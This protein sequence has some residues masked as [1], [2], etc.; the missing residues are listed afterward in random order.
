MY[1]SFMLKI[2]H[3][4]KVRLTKQRKSLVEAAK[5]YAKDLGIDNVDCHVNIVFTHMLT[6][7][8]F[9]HA[10]VNNINERRINILI[11]AKMKGNDMGLSTMAHEMVHVKQY[12]RKELGLTKNGEHITWNGKKV[13]SSL[14]YY[15]TP[16]EME[17]MQK[18]VIMKYKYIDFLGLLK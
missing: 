11:D 12:I 6:E 10:E 13:N 17:A 7:L 4:K 2:T 18:E 16:W 8:F 3:N 1:N 9:V 15:E 5:F 14:K